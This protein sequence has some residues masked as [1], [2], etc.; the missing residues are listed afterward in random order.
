MSIRTRFVGLGM[1]LALLPVVVGIL[2]WI[3]SRRVNQAEK[4][5]QI[6][7][8]LEREVFELTLL[9]HE[10]SRFRSARA[11]RQLDASLRN[12][13]EIIR[14]ISAHSE[15]NEEELIVSRLL[16]HQQRLR[17]LVAELKRPLSVAE[18]ANIDND[19]IASWQS[20]L[21]G[22]LLI[23]GQQ[24]LADARQL[25]MRWTNQLVE[26]QQITDLIVLSFLVVA[27]IV[28]AVTLFLLY[29]GIVPPLGNLVA[30]VSQLARGNRTV[31]VAATSRGEI[32]ELCLAFNAMASELQDYQE[33]LE[34]LVERRTSEL[35]QS[36]EEIEQ[37][38]IELQQ[39]A[40][41][42]SHDL[43]TPLRSISGFAQ[44]LRSEYEGKLDDEADD[45]IR[46]VVDGAERM[47]TLIRDLLAYSRVESRSQPFQQVDIALVFDDAVAQLEASISDA[48]AEV[49]R[50]DL[51]KIMGDHSQLVQLLQNLIG[52]GVKYHGDEPPCVHISAERNGVQW[53]FSVRD[54]GIGIEA[55][56]Y[57]KVFDIFRRLHT[58]QEYPGTGIGL[59]VCRRVV[60]RHGG[61]L[62]VESEPGQGSTFYFSIPDS[63]TSGS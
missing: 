39:F 12:L 50:G 54:N 24:L 27:V 13:D 5:T 17:D 60:H 8:N 3:T 42:A 29:R 47:Q 2:F 19:T 58:Q 31:R 59:A 14:R 37:S 21:V 6:A 36:N 1:L 43:Q 18:D 55:K 30:A 40:Y 48:E 4:K 26:A 15:Y 35:R 10:F 32:G 11:Q 44:L 16:R 61:K 33:H 22:Q 57:E 23:N 38:N 25:S 9:T 41:I 51:P 56:H 20:R 45:W 62:W 49:T 34:E 52:N 46:R 7:N 28:G 63:E 53:T